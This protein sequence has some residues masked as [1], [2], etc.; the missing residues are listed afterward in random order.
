MLPLSQHMQ[1]ND[2]DGPRQDNKREDD[3][4]DPRVMRRNMRNNRYPIPDKEASKFIRAKKNLE[5]SEAFDLP[6]QPVV[7]T[8]GGGPS[9]IFAMARRM[10][11]SGESGTT[12][13]LPRWRPTLTQNSGISNFNPSFRTSSPLMNNNGY[14]GT[15]WRNARKR[16]KPSLWRYALRTYDRMDGSLEEEGQSASP[17]SANNSPLQETANTEEATVVERLNIHHQGALLAVAKLGLWEKAIEIYTAVEMEQEKRMIRKGMTRSKLG[18][19][20]LQKSI[21]K[22]PLHVTD[23][24][25][26]SMIYA[27]VR[28]CRKMSSLDQS[29]EERRK[30][31]DAACDILQ[32]VEDKHGINLETRHYNPLAAAYQKLQLRE[33]AERLISMLKDRRIGPEPEEGS[34]PFNINDVG[35]KDKG[36]YTLLVSGAVLEEDWTGAIAA[37]RNMTDAGLYPNQRHL[38][39]WTE[40]SERKTKNRTTRSWKKKRDEE[41]IERGLL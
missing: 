36:S 16:K 22:L 23:D 28:A 38:N 6:E 5:A 24:M 17:V 41:W 18:E 31:L 20:N 40:V 33:E 34:Q 1:G 7:K 29:L 30:P 37:L 35:T 13:G 3:P 39:A 15:I 25:V 19:K 9:M 11:E 21:R 27:C 2:T 26:V 4:N 10:W 14:A 32:T 8:I 12:A